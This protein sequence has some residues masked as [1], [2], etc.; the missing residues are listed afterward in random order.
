MP[1]SRNSREV[2]KRKKLDFTELDP[3]HAA[4][5]KIGGLASHKRPFELRVA[6]RPVDD[7]R[8]RGATQ[9]LDGSDWESSSS[10]SES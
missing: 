7:V 9:A 6:R 10:S 1:S 3:D 8:D 5:Y 2:L 4:S